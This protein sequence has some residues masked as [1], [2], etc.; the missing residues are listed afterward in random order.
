MVEN[1]DSN[2][3]INNYY[4]YLNKCEDNKNLTDALEEYN[5]KSKPLSENVHFIIEFANQQLN[6]QKRKKEKILIGKKRSSTDDITL[7][8]EDISEYSDKIKKKNILNNII[9]EI[10]INYIEFHNK[11][12]KSDF[13]YQLNFTIKKNMINNYIDNKDILDKNL[14][15]IIL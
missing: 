3:N 2:I 10:P 15:E 7:T 11:I 9:S 13:N 14:E 6:T 5:Y 12:Y 4:E 1:K 8:K